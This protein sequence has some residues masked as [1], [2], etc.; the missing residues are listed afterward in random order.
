M[1]QKPGVIYTNCE[2]CKARV[3]VNFTKGAYLIDLEKSVKAGQKAI[4]DLMEA[5][6]A[7]KHRRDLREMEL[8]AEIKQ[9][10]AEI[11]FM[12]DVRS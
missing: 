8:Q 10:K 12:H 6:R 1:S 7:E 3:K 5:G 4:V 2:K 9:L 11:D